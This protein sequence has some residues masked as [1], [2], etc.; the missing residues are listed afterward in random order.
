MTLDGQR[1]DSMEKIIAFIKGSTC[2]FHCPS[3]PFF[4]KNF[5]KCR[6]TNFYNIQII[7][8]IREKWKDRYVIENDMMDTRWKVFEFLHEIP[9]EK[10]VEVEPCGKCLNELVLLGEI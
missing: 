8:R 2:A 5:S 7:G 9:K 1:I 10:Q 4:K 3:K 6:Y